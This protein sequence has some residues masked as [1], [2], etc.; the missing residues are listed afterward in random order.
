MPNI[1][2]DK[3]K[4]YLEDIC[5][6]NNEINSFK[7]L[8]KERVKFFG[9]IPYTITPGIRHSEIISISKCDGVLYYKP[10]DKNPKNKTFEIS[11]D[12]LNKILN[13]Q[14]ISNS[15]NIQQKINTGISSE[16]KTNYCYIIFV[17][18]IL[19]FV[20]VIVKK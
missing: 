9:G 2:C 12:K 15:N 4:L 3:C 14:D 17:L 20:I 1:K 11:M 6:D 7:S 13:E 8:L 19:F 16:I 10:F 5:N 18:F